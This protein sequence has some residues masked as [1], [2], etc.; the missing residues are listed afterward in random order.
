MLRLDKDGTE[1]MLGDRLA[2][3][4]SIYDFQIFGT[5]VEGNLGSNARGGYDKGITGVRAYIVKYDIDRRKS[6]IENGSLAKNEIMNIKAEGSTSSKELNPRN[7][8]NSDDGKWIVRRIISVDKAGNIT[9]YNSAVLGEEMRTTYG[10]AIDENLT[11]SK[12]DYYIDTIPPEILMDNPDDYLPTAKQDT[13]RYIKEDNGYFEKTSGAYNGYNFDF[14]KKGDRGVIKYSAKDFNALNVGDFFNNKIDVIDKKVMVEGKIDPTYEEEY[15]GKH[16][17]TMK[18]RSQEIKIESDANGELIYTV[19][20]ED[21]AGNVNNGIVKVDV[22]NSKDIEFRVFPNE[23]IKRWSDYAGIDIQGSRNPSYTKEDNI[24]FGFSSDEKMDLEVNGNVLKSNSGT[25]KTEDFLDYNCFSLINESSD[26]K[27]ALKAAV[28]QKSIYEG[29]GIRKSGAKSENPSKS[30]IILDKTMDITENIFENITVLSNKN[31]YEFE[32]DFSKIKDY[33]GVAAYK[34]DD[35]KSI[36]VDSKKKKIKYNYKVNNGVNNEIS[37]SSND[38]MSVNIT[39]SKRC[40]SETKA[41]NGSIPI[42][43]FKLSGVGAKSLGDEIIITIGAWDQLGNYGTV[44]KRL[45]FGRNMK[46]RATDASSD[47]EVSSEV[48]TDTGIEIRDRIEAGRE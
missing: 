16:R 44:S 27:T 10:T 39:F 22:M 11:D 8:N 4:N 36:K 2:Y 12:L 42:R 20:A 23:V 32:I 33:S 14:V 28:G 38:K 40:S 45:L 29:R 25:K 35:F 1:Y 3:I 41:G 37:L 31:D 6:D 30:S 43:T 9:K 19:Y 46:V 15:Q 34:I 17:R 24:Y 7:K 48:K 13:H 21:K 47:R 18:C 5:G 26:V